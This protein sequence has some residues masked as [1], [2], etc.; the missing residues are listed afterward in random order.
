MK[1]TEMPDFLD[2]NTLQLLLLELA[3]RIDWKGVLPM[4]LHLEDVRRNRKALVE[5]L[6]EHEPHRFL[7]LPIADEPVWPEQIWYRDD[8]EVWHLRAVADERL[9]LGS[10]SSDAPNWITSAFELRDRCLL[11]EGHRRVSLTPTAFLN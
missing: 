1:Q 10:M 7:P 2:L 11:I 9:I 3:I 6:V 4:G 8:G 5:A